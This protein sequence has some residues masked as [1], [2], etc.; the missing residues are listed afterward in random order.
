[1][2]LIADILLVAAALAATFYCF[3]LSRRLS[4]FNDLEKGVGGAVAV[5]SAQVDDMTKTLARAQTAAV[6]STSSL[7]SLTKRAEDVAAR[8]ELLVAAMH[9]LPVQGATG[10][11]KSEQGQK[12]SGTE[13]G[14]GRTTARDAAPEQKNAKPAEPREQQDGVL[15]GEDP[16]RTGPLFLRHRDRLEEAAQ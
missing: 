11:R 5:M 9:D 6:G 13:T 2:N 7:E 12:P 15:P 3:I 16:E 1:M 14:P 8:L 4:R 10:A